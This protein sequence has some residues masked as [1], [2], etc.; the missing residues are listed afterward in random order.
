MVTDI[1]SV[2][3]G[4]L[5]TLNVVVAVISLLLGIAIVVF[6]WLTEEQV[7]GVVAIAVG[8]YNAFIGFLAKA[9]L[10]PDENG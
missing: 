5:Y 7:L 1:P 10:T 6:G 4:N 9:H 3:R 2:V 8:L